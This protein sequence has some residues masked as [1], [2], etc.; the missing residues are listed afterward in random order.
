MFDGSRP[1]RLQV[2]PP[3]SRNGFAAPSLSIWMSI[4]QISHL[5]FITHSVGGPRSRAGVMRRYV[6][7]S[8]PMPP[9]EGCCIHTEESFF[10]G[11]NLVTASPRLMTT[12]VIVA[13]MIMQMVDLPQATSC[14]RERRR[15]LVSFSV[16]A[17]S[18]FGL[19]PLHRDYTG[20]GSTL[21]EERFM[22]SCL[23][24]I[25]LA[26]LEIP[27]HIWCLA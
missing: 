9:P 13:M 4:V 14:L 15:L 10:W 17:A 22:E 16:S 8:S 24:K 23:Y 11:H 20:G 19:C 1:R 21:S 26:P 3:L 6:Q 5:L 27:I 2:N 12:A 18:F 25:A 7:S